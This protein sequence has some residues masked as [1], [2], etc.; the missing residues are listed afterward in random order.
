MEWNPHHLLEG[1]EG[2]NDDVVMEAYLRART[3]LRVRGKLIRDIAEGPLATARWRWDTERAK[4][5]GPKLF[6]ATVGE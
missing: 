4:N 3:Y 2:L 5:E 6:E 1:A